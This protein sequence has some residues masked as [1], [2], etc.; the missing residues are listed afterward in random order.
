MLT[1]SG[2]VVRVRRVG[3]TT[4]SCD[5]IFGLVGLEK[6]STCCDIL[7]GLVSLENFEPAEILLHWGVRMDGNSHHTA[8]FVQALSLFYLD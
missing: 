8:V 3:A 1:I 4:F 5:L 6:A 2:N 7:L